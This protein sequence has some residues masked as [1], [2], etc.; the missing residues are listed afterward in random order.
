MIK[1]THLYY[2]SL[3]WVVG[4]ANSASTTNSVSNLDIANDFADAFYS[5][6]RDSLQALL[7]AAESSQPE[8]LYYQKWA[9]CG[10]YQVLHRDSYVELNDSTVLFP[11]TVKDDLMGAL[12]ID[13]N[14]TDTFRIT[15]RNGKIRSVQTSSND[16][17]EYYTAKE[18]VKTHRP[19]YVEKACEGIWQG[20]PTPCECIQGMVRGFRDFIA[21]KGH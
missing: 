8:I 21:Q 1:Y 14:V 20:G 9:E 11:V 2:L 15:L 18:W 5:F 19:E 7:A 6:N 4:C 16:L 13:F 3:L 10:N 17:D 12:Q